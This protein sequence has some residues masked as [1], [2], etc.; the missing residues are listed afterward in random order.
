MQVYEQRRVRFSNIDGLERQD[1]AIAGE[2][3]LEEVGR[4][5]WVSREAIRLATHFVR[6]MRSPDPDRMLLREIESE[7]QLGRDDMLKTLK[8]M[9]TYGAVEAFSCDRTDLRVSLNLSYLQRLRVL[10]ATHRFAELAT[11]RGRSPRPW[12]ERERVHW[13]P[14]ASEAEPVAEPADAPQGGA[15][16]VV[17]LVAAE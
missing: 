13:R 2:V 17:A 16:E 14:A 4:A 5:P 12:V 8:Q 6:Y 11:Q 9:R 10:E 15:E 1:L 7:V 3:W